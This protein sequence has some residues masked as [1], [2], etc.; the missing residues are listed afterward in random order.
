MDGID[1]NSGE[2]GVAVLKHFQG[3]TIGTNLV[4]LAIEWLSITVRWPI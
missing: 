4:E 2:L 1:Q 3:Y